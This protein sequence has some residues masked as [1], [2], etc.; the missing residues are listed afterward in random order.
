[1]LSLRMVVNNDRGSTAS[2]SKKQATTPISPRNKIPAPS[3][4]SQHG[5]HSVNRPVAQQQ[6]PTISP[7]PA[8]GPKGLGAALRPVTTVSPWQKQA[9]NKVMS[10]SAAA[11]SSSSTVTAPQ[12]SLAVGAG[13]PPADAQTALTGQMSG[14][15]VTSNVSNASNIYRPPRGPP[16]KQAVY[17]R[18]TVAPAH[19]QN[20]GQGLYDPSAGPS[21][22]AA[23]MNWRANSNASASS[24][25]TR[26]PVDNGVCK[27]YP[28][29]S[30]RDFRQ[31][32]VI[33]LPFHQPN[34]NPH[35]ATTDPNLTVHNTFGGIYSKRRMMVVLY[36]YSQDMFCLPL[37]S[38]NGK[39]AG[40]RP[41][42]LK[43]EY[44]G[45]K[46]S[47]D[48]YY[49]NHC[50]HKPVVIEGN[51]NPMTPA[52]TIVLTA[53]LKVDCREDINKV[54]RLTKPTYAHMLSLWRDLSVKAQQQP[55]N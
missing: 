28:N 2:S 41:E 27:Y 26:H 30:G 29:R 9:A 32:D 4:P 36:I 34:T 53:G 18:S 23:S 49:E 50:D 25:S 51:H 44:V 6:T 48:T 21:G 10:Y 12:T 45:V 46:N 47:T 5:R 7:P 8:P 16:Q 37:Y 42:D 43:H 1:M 20:S 15:R 14:L 17:N 35:V 19:N 52:T 55:W 40:G 3:T 54:G 31:G 11:T 33:S 38:W 13:S 24:K 39:G 22:S